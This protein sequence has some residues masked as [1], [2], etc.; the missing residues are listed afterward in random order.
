MQPLAWEPPYAV[1]AAL[2]KKE[3]K[4]KGAQVRDMSC[5]VE[6]DLLPAS[7]SA[8][9]TLMLLLTKSVDIPLPHST[10]NSLTPAGCSTSQVRSDTMDL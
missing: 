1:G 6:K 3:R 7:L 4:K 5:C 8:S 9:T 10:P 2:K